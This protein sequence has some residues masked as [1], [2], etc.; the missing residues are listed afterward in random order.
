MEQISIELDTTDS[1]TEVF[2][3]KEEPLP[4][5]RHSSEESREKAE[6][7][8]PHRR[9]EQKLIPTDMNYFD[10]S[11]GTSSTP[12]SR[13]SDTPENSKQLKALEKKITT[14]DSRIQKTPSRK[15]KPDFPP[16]SELVITGTRTW[17]CVFGGAVAS[18][19][20]IIMT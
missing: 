7:K 18:V 8:V 6:Q 10:T 20:V 5:T 15:P 1:R 2:N 14:A 4:I 11:N 3:K 13:K 12:M 19:T 9:T 16:I 17:R